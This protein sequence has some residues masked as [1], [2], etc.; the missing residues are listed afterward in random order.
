MDSSNS[1]I[2]NKAAALAV[3]PVAGPRAQMAEG[4]HFGRFRRKQTIRVVSAFFPPPSQWLRREVFSRIGALAPPNR[5]Y[6]IASQG[7]ENWFGYI[8]IPIIDDRVC[9]RLARPRFFCVFPFEGQLFS[10]LPGR[11][12]D[13]FNK[14][15][16]A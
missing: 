2:S 14:P 5:I 10:F 15:L 4:G 13:C 11:N 16:R 9:H 3:M 12:V 8:G 6:F 1:D 7:F